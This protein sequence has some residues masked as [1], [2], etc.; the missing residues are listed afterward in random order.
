M[1]CLKLKTA[2]DG[3]Y[4]LPDFMGCVY[5]AL[6]DAKTLGAYR[7]ATGDNWTPPKT[8]AEK[9]IDQAT[10]ADTAFLQR[11]SDWVEQNLFGRPEDLNTDEENAA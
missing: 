11:F 5:W 3:H 8:P 9:M 6:G 2:W 7:K 4:M 1:D 10:G